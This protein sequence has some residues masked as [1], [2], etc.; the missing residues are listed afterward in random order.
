MEWGPDDQVTEAVLAGRRQY[1][2]LSL[3]DSRWV[4]ADLTHRGYSVAEIA[5]WL[6]CSAR[7]V[8]RVRAE[9]VTQV[10]EALLREQRRAGD[11]ERRY[12]SVRGEMKRLRERCMVLEARSDI[13]VLAALSQVMPLDTRVPPLPQEPPE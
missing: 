4:V 3:E 5:G 13:Q 1:A 12:G 8:K 2:D 11:A 9:L 10:M 6:R 7:Q